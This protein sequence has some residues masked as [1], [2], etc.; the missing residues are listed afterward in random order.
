[1]IKKI[2]PLIKW[3]SSAFLALL[4]FGAIG[5]GDVL[6]SVFM[7]SL[8]FLVTPLSNKYL[9][10]KLKF[11]VPTWGKVLLGVFLFFSFGA[12]LT[13]SQSAPEPEIAEVVAN[14]PENK[15]PIEPEVIH[16]EVTSI[17]DG[18]TIK[19]LIN[20]KTETIRLVNV[21]TPETVDPR[22]PVECMGKEASEKMTQLVTGKKV[23]LEIDETQ[24]DRDRYD[25]LLRFVFMEDGTDVG[26][27]M[28]K[29]GFAESSPYGNSPHKY[30]EEYKTAQSQAQEQQL[31]LWNST[32]CPTPTNSPQQTIQNSG[33]GGGTS[34]NTSPATQP[35]S[36]GVVK[37]S[38]NDI[39]HAPGTTYYEKTTN[40]TAY[41]SVD[42]CL[43]SGGR[44][45][46]R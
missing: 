10:S 35:P 19:V 16:Y 5:M 12:T 29:Q 8:A 27:E 4:A 9:F 39:C 13:P 7:F 33:S 25:R 37:K 41:N 11:A 20:D 38:T 42:E 28:I 22:R 34:S 2:L 40:Y 1:M 44:L 30:L 3:V 31:G 45:P 23:S 46:K 15:E 21:N 26:L 24:T 32:V 14:A 36:S 17:T 43:A 18:D 6:A